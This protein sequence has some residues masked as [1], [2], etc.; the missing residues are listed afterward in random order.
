MMNTPHPEFEQIHQITLV[1]VH[2]IMSLAQDETFDMWRGFMPRLNEISNRVGKDLFSVQVFRSGIQ[3]LGKTDP[4]EKWAAVKVSTKD[5]VPNG[6]STLELSGMY[7]R[8]IHHGTPSS[9]HL[10]L[11]G[12]FGNWLPSSGY[13]LDDRPHFEIMPEGYDRN[14]PNAIEFVFIPIRLVR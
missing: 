11:Q 10:T 8:F 3:S 13:Q 2:R 4:F 5:D 6:M 12:I 9:F 14:D 7:A 1:G